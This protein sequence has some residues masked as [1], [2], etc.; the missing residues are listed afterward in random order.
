MI[1][2]AKI[3]NFNRTDRELQAFWLFCIMV[4]GK[5]SD[6]T[7]LKLNKMLKEMG[8]KTPF[9]FITEYYGYGK[10]FLLFLYK[11][12]TGQYKRISEAFHAS[13]FLDLRNAT[14]DELMSVH[15]VGPKTARF[16]ILHS[17]ANARVAV[18]D[19]HILKWLTMYGLK[20]VPDTTPNEKEYAKWEKI[21]L[22]ICDIWYRGKPIAEVDLNIWNG[23]RMAKHILTSPNS[24]LR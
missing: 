7:A 23:M 5:N 18:L 8:E 11:H 21:F 24:M 6:Q 1:D 9:E 2:P 22:D 10:Q 17:R 19:T 16:F 4:A 15:G 13:I 20:D 3:T 14:L 12:K